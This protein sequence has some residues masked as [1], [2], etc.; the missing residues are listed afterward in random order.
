MHIN[1]RSMDLYDFLAALAG[2]EERLD[3]LKRP[4]LLTGRAKEASISSI[5][6]ILTTRAAAIVRGIETCK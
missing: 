6:L 1:L 2:D 5:S 3:V 4:L